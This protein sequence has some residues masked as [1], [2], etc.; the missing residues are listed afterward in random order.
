MM[1]SS[2]RALLTRNNRELPR[3]VAVVNDVIF[4][5]KD[6][7]ANAKECHILSR[8]CEILRD[9]SGEKNYSR[10]PE[11]LLSHCLRINDEKSW[12]ALCDDAMCGLV[13]REC[14][15]SHFTEHPNDAACFAWQFETAGS[16]AHSAYI[17]KILSLCI[18]CFSKEAMAVF[19][20]SL[21]YGKGKAL[22]TSYARHCKSLPPKTRMLALETFGSLLTIDTIFEAISRDILC[23]LETHGQFE[24]VLTILMASPCAPRLGCIFY[25]DEARKALVTQFHM[26]ALKTPLPRRHPYIIALSHLARPEDTELQGLIVQSLKGCGSLDHIL[27]GICKLIRVITPH[28]DLLGIFAARVEERF[29][30]NVT[31]M[32]EEQSK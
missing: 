32:K 12:E 14:V 21:R 11:F 23:S 29:T 24:D 19:S 22:I 10:D 2:L 20:E 3:R 9:I 13:S 25:E 30:N 17:V 7:P 4:E 16:V 28:E 18:Q 27:D 5:L 1:E 6:A 26:L 8:V 31:E 15:F